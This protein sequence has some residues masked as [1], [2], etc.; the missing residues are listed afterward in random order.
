MPIYE[1]RC[2][3]CDH[4]FESWQKVSDP[5]PDKCPSCGASKVE[6][7]I[8]STSFRLKG[9]GWY[10]SDYAGKKSSWEDNV[11]KKGQEVAAKKKAESEAASSAAKTADKSVSVSSSSGSSGSSSSSGSGSSTKGE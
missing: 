4:V 6:K 1:F 10:A 8:S 3:E 11:S 5:N 7:L 2:A 9:G